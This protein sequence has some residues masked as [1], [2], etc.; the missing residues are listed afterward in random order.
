MSAMCTP[1]TR[2][3]QGGA[4]LRIGQAVAHVRQQVDAEINEQHHQ[5]K[6]L[7]G[8]EIVHQEAIHGVTA[9]PRQRKHHLNQHHAADEEADL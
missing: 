8:C 4:H 6:P 9:D 7:H 2:P 1:Q 3:L 5:H